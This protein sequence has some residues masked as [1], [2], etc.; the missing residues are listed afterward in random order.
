[1]VS[2]RMLF[3]SVEHRYSIRDDLWA[4]FYGIPDVKSMGNDDIC[5]IGSNAG[6]LFSERPGA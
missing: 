5:R 6:I 3:R 2:A 4:K 1:M